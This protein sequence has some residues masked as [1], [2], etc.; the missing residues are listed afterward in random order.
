MEIEVKIYPSWKDDSGITMLGTMDILLR[1]D[2]PFNG[3]PTLRLDYLSSGP[4]RIFHDDGRVCRFL[5]HYV[6]GSSVAVQLQMFSVVVKMLMSWFSVGHHLRRETT[7]SCL[8]CCMASKY[9]RIRS[10]W[11]RMHGGVEADHFVKVAEQP[12]LA[13]V[14]STKAVAG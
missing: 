9:P 12:C 8:I 6:G 10:V 5:L 14:V 1:I 13:S 11:I 2:I 3:P 4:E 7:D